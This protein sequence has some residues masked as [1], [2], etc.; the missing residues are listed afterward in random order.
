MTLEPTWLSVEEAGG[1][2]HLFYQFQTFCT[3]AVVVKKADSGVLLCIPRNGIPMRYFEEAEEHHYPGDLGPFTEAS[4]KALTTARQ[5]ERFLEVVLFDLDRGG[6]SNLSSACPEGVSETDCTGFGRFKNAAEWPSPEA[7]LEVA[8]NF[9]QTGGNRLDAYFSAQEPL[10]EEGLGEESGAEIANGEDGDS[11]NVLL[12]RLL[13]QSE[14][15]QRTVTGMRDRV[16]SLDKLEARLAVLEKSRA[17]G[18]TPKAAPAPQ[19][20]DVADSALTPRRQARLHQLAGRGPARLRDLGG[21]PPSGL[22]APTEPPGGTIVEA[23]EEEEEEAEVPATSSTLEQL[24]ASQSKL[25]EKLVSAKVQSTDPFSLLGSGSADGEEAPKSSGVRGIAAR[26]VLTENFKKHPERV[27]ALFRERLTLARRKASP[28]ELEPRDLWYHFQDTVPLGSHKT[29]TYLAFIS[30]V[31]F[32]AQER[33][34]WKR[35]QMLVVLQSVFIEQAAHDGGSLR[36]AH[37]L[38]CLEDPPFSQTELHRAPRVEVPHGQLA[39]PRWVATQLAYL[40]DI[41]TIADKSNKFKGGPPKILDATTEDAVPKK[42]PKWRPKKPK[43]ASEST[44]GEG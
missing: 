24:L 2:T 42:G 19:L 8:N 40:R 39:D 27:V 34:D 16:A 20:F 36:L 18:A 37:L 33:G 1:P 10:G 41:E 44:E 7:I 43:K 13:T 5:K 14:L 17:L 30:A 9:L 32:E 4:V 26:Q 35:L 38:T 12:K 3:R 28:A 23:E 22:P 15:T 31:M 6:L 25:L 11:M 29:L 21:A